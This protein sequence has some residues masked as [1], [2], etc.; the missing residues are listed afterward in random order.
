MWDFMGILKMTPNATVWI[1]NFHLYEY[2]SWWFL[3]WQSRLHVYL[4]EHVLWHKLH[5]YSSK[6]AC[7]VWGHPFMTSTQSRGGSQAQVEACGRGRVQP[8]VDVHTEN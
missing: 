2:Y 1:H 8:H 6:D 7:M 3:S 4:C 5:F